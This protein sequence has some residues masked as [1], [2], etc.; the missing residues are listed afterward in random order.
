MVSSFIKPQKAEKDAPKD[1]FERSR[2]TIR[3]KG[4]GKYCKY[5]YDFEFC[6]RQSEFLCVDV[7]RMRN[8][9]EILKRRNK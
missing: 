1:K 6:Y 4:E 9:K 5:L 8:I 3:V 7:I 2:C